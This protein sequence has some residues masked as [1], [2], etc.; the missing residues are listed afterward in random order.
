MTKIQTLLLAG[1]T[2]VAVLTSTTLSAQVP[3][4]SNVAANAAMNNP[5]MMNAGGKRATRAENH[6]FSK[7]VLRAI[8][9]NRTVGDADISVFGNAATGTVVLVGYVFDEKQEQAAVDAARQV[10]GVTDVTSRLMMQLHG[11]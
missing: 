5:A 10:A 11:D 4:S 2:V 8:Y 7:T 6:R 3:A 1:L 9:D